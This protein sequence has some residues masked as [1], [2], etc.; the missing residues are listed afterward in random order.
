MHLRCYPHS[1]SASGVIYCGLPE[2]AE[3]RFL[4]D[5]LR[6]GEGFVDVGANIGTYSLLAASVPDVVAWAF[7]PSRD[8]SD[9]PERTS[10]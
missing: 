9:A 10:S 3:M 1:T 8:P 5:Y 2:W 4:L 6:P 7:E